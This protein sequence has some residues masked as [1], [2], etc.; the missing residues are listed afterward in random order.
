MA[1]QLTI[2]VSIYGYNEHRCDVLLKK[3]LPEQAQSN[4]VVLD[5]W[6]QK[7]VM[8]IGFDM[9]HSQRWLCEICGDPAREVVLDP[10]PNLRL[11]D[12]VVTLNMHQLCEA[13]GGPCHSAVHELIR[14]Q[15]LAAGSPPSGLQQPNATTAPLAGSCIAAS[16]AKHKI[17]R[18]IARLA[19]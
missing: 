18:D 17:G 7:S 9:K 2:Q 11:E 5:G 10:K 14:K 4:L 12:P 8:A 3:D 19:K 1:K 16:H 15:A 13:Q 6:A